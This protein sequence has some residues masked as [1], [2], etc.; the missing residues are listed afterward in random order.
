MPYLARELLRQ[1]LL[2]S[3]RDELGLGTRDPVLRESG[4]PPGSAPTLRLVLTHEFP[5][6]KFFEFS[7]RRQSG[8]KWTPLFEGT[9]PYEAGEAYDYLSLVAEAERLSRTSLPDVLRQAGVEAHPL[10]AANEDPIPEKLNELLWSLNTID[11]FAAVREL[12]AL[13]R[14]RGESPQLLGGLARGYA[15]LGVLTEMHWNMSNK[16]LKAR[17]LL[18]AQR[19]MARDPSPAGP[20]HRAYALALAG[21]HSDGL[22]DLAEARKQ[23][24]IIRERSVSESQPATAPTPAEPPPWL[25]TIEAICK[26]DTEKLMRI[27]EA[28]EESSG[29]AS[30]MHILQ[31]DVRS[32]STTQG[33]LVLRLVSEHPECTRALSLLNRSGKMGHSRLAG[34]AALEEVDMALRER[35]PEVPGLPENIRSLVDGMEELTEP[36]REQAGDPCLLR[37][38]IMRGLV[39]AGEPRNDSG[40]PSWTLLGH[41]IE[42]EYFDHVQEHAYFIRGRLGSNAASFVEWAMGLIADHPYRGYVDNY[43]YSRGRAK[44]T[45]LRIFATCRRLAPTTYYRQYTTGSITARKRAIPR[46][47]HRTWPFVPPW[48]GMQLFAMPW[49]RPIDFRAGKGP[50][51]RAS[52]WR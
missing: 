42:E 27:A 33:E 21:R 46:P 23:A 38:G 3:A 2:I 11:Q 41:L 15:N 36:T 5:N 25:D 37:T 4:G 39:V 40:E 9:A 31:G 10:P 47:P 48:V 45:P 8:D 32:L 28:Q 34:P 24:A 16:V 6:G 43:R 14:T 30:L 20:A 52:C 50:F 22:A 35:L 18:Y 19:L 1:A 12:H 44:Q 17:A 13:I 7:V 29:W 51:L 26:V 49:P